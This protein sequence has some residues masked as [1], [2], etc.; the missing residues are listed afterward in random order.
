MYNP[1]VNYVKKIKSK[2]L[3]SSTVVLIRLMGIS[4]LTYEPGLVGFA[5]LHLCFDSE[6]SALENDQADYYLINGHYQL[7]IYW[8][9]NDRFIS[10]S[11]LHGNYAPI[12][13]SSILVSIDRN[14]ENPRYPPDY[15]EGVYN[16]VFFQVDES[17]YRLFR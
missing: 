7:P 3:P 15:S 9:N 4:T 10:L 12:P 11:Q 16:T 1:T 14:A 13:C 2:E 5:Y 6:G 17:D 8:G